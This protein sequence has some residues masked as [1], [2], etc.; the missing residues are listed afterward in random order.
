MAGLQEAYGGQISRF[1]L[2]TGEPKIDKAVR[3]VVAFGGKAAA[4]TYP[5]RVTV[6]SC[7][8]PGTH[9]RDGQRRNVVNI[10]MTPNADMILGKLRQIQPSL[11]RLA[12]PWISDAIEGQVRQLERV[13]GVE[14]WV[15]RL[16]QREDLPDRLREMLDAKVEALWLPPDPLLINAQS[17]LMIK[18]F[19]WANDIPFY[20]PTAG[21]VKQGAVGAV[22]CSFRTMGRTAGQVT[23]QVLEG[24]QYESVVYPT[25]VEIILSRTAASNSG[26]VIPAQMWQDAVQVLP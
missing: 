10:P 6:I 9:V 16:T 7:L 11:R 19:C 15:A 18:T 23:R 13:A 1:S 2:A 25:Q 20:V 17:L 12:V 22:A 3:V 21:L 14:V 26:V 4:R 5:D 24:G 8:A